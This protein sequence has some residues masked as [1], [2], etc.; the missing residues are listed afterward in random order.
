MKILITLLQQSAGGAFLYTEELYKELIKNH[1]VFYINGKKLKTNSLLELKSLELLKNIKFDLIIIMQSDHY[2]KLNINFESNKIINIIHSEVYD[3]DQP[4]ILNNIKYIAVREEISKY[5][6]NN[7]NINQ[8]SILTLLNPINED[9]YNKINDLQDDFV[10]NKFGIFA[11]GSLAQIRLNAA[12]EFSHHCRENK[13]KSLF[14][15]NTHNEAKDNLNQFYDKIIDATP[16]INYYMKHA[17]ICGGIQK[18]RTYW[19]AKLLG[20]PVLEYMVESN[21]EIIYEIYE[22]SPTYEELKNIKEITHP[23]YVVNQIIEWAFN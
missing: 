13:I 9:F 19:E 22:K 11:C 6:I 2:K 3:V 20:K 21:G 4:L 18:G 12:I 23:E 8:N 7:F 15:G 5:L 14:V 17:A 16:N 1:K 10:K